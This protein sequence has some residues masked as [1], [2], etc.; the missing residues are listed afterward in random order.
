MS[1]VAE[2][3]SNPLVDGREGNFGLLAGFHRHADEGGVGVGR[4][5]VW[6]GLVVNVLR[7]LRVHGHGVVRRPRGGGGDGLAGSVGHAHARRVGG[8][9]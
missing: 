8:Q 9:G 6:V 1:E 5:D 2:V 7:E 3:V 4:L